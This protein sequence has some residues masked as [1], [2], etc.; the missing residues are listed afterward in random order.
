MLLPLEGDRT[1]IALVQSPANDSDASFSPDGKWLA[2]HSRMSGPGLEIY[3]QAFSGDGKIG[4]TGSR[5]HISTDGGGAGPSW[6]GDGRE[7]YYHSGGR[8]MVAAIRFAPEFQAE[9]PRELFQTELNDGGLHCK[10]VTADGTKFIVVLKARQTQ[11]EA[12]LT[13]VTDW[14][15]K[16]QR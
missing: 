11:S 6:R 4:L 15:A 13:V 9:R 1:P 7:L 2:Y 3:V 10:A 8:I 14:Q 5:Y 12:R 16:L